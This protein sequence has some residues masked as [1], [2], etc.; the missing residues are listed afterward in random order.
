[1]RYFKALLVMCMCMSI[2]VMAFLL[3]IHSFRS[4]RMLSLQTVA[5]A[6]ASASASASADGNEKKV[7]G[8]NNISNEISKIIESL[9]QIP[10]FA[11][12]VV[13]STIPLILSDNAHILSH[14]NDYENVINDKI[15]GSTDTSKLEK[16][17]A[18]VRPFV[19]SERQKRARMKLGT[20]SF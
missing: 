12:L 11:E 5:S 13:N 14:R 18:Y 20:S 16:V 8:K 6:R 19:Q 2:M 4:Q 15:A 10:N 7:Y 1:M 9:L 17:D 3:P